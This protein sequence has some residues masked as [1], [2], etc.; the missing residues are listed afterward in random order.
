MRADE[1]T[2]RSL[3]QVE[4]K[5]AKATM[6]PRENGE[7]SLN[8]H[9]IMLTSQII[10]KKCLTTDTLFSSRIS[11]GLG[12]LLISLHHCVASTGFQ[13]VEVQCG[14]KIRLPL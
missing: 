14:T 9:K 8:E 7:V 10:V 1:D 13:C 5:M 12:S 3:E 11:D 6:I 2:T 4:E